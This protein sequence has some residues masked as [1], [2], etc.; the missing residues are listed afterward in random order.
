MSKKKISTQ[1][2][3]LNILLVEDDLLTNKLTLALLKK[4][5]VKADFA[6]TGKKAI[7]LCSHKNYELIFMDYHLPDM[8]GNLIIEKI[9]AS[10]NGN[11]PIIIGISACLEKSKLHPGLNSFIEK[12]ITREKIDFCLS[13]IKKEAS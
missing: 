5:P 6:L 13:M 12:P 2:A 9:R 3:I 1:H 4:F 11:N 10:S 7:E 8:K